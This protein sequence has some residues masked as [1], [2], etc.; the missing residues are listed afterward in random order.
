MEGQAVRSRA[1]CFSEDPARPNPSAENAT[2]ISEIEVSNLG[3]PPAG[4]YSPQ[5][6]VPLQSNKCQLETVAESDTRPAKRPKVPR[7]SKP[8]GP[9]RRSS[10]IRAQQQFLSVEGGL[11]QSHPPVSSRLRPVTEAPTKKRKPKRAFAEHRRLQEQDVQPDTQARKPVPAKHRP[12]AMQ[13]RSSGRESRP[14]RP[15]PS[16][17]VPGKQQKVLAPTKLTRENLRFLDKM[18]KSSSKIPRSKSRSRSKATTDDTKTTKTTSTTFS[19]FAALAFENGVLN[20]PNSKPPKNLD[21]LRARINRSRGTASPPESAYRAYVHAVQTA[22]NEDSMVH[23]SVRLLK[24]FDDDLQYAK[25]YNQSFNSFPSDVGFN[26]GLSVPKPDLVEALQR[27]AF[28]PFPVKSELGGSAVLI[29]DPDSMTLPH[30]AGEWKGR[31]KDME[32]ARTQSAYDGARN[33]SDLNDGPN[34][35][36]VASMPTMSPL[37]DVP[38]AGPA[39]MDDDSE[40]EIVELSSCSCSSTLDPETEG[41]GEESQATSGQGPIVDSFIK[42]PHASSR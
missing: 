41:S 30:L 1:L 4:Q 23:I 42:A 27:P 36:A 13:V 2:K 40:F 19:G 35:S 32:E 29:D 17:H 25:V 5:S 26:N 20:P 7:T 10:R 14:L 21:D 6:L 39:P 15:P 3:F 12:P 22:P 28:R 9:L 34:P 11:P 38:P 8:P 24:D 18:T 37:E 16:G 31:G 33:A